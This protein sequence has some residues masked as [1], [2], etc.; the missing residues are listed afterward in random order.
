[1][2]AN[3]PKAFDHEKAFQAALAYELND[4]KVFVDPKLDRFL[5]HK[6]RQ[7]SVEKRVFLPGLLGTTSN[8]MGLSKV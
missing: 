3:R 5:E 2:A 6:S 7:F 8:A 1:M 4:A